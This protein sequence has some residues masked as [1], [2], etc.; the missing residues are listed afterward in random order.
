MEAGRSLAGCSYRVSGAT[1][2]PDVELR[3][4]TNSQINTHYVN[5]GIYQRILAALRE[6]GIDPVA[7]TVADLAPIDQFHTGGLPATRSLAERLEINP[8][9]K[10]LDAGCGIGGGARFLADAYGCAVVGPDLAEEF[11]EAAAPPM[12][13]WGWR[14]RCPARW[15]TSRTPGSTTIR[16]IWFGA[17]TY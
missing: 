2:R 17:R 9:T 7:A 12:S 14:T 13:C 6:A 3:L 11:I 16:S 15:A 10:V 8:R 4:N 1:Y 5:D